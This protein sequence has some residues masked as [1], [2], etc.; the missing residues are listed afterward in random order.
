[1]KSIHLC[2][3]TRKKSDFYCVTDF[4]KITTIILFQKKHFFG[5][6]EVS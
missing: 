6:L 1:M 2:L 5:V 3:K 4:P